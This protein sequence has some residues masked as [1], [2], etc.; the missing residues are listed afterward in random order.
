MAIKQHVSSS[1]LDRY[2]HY[3]KKNRP[4]YYNAHLDKS[5][6]L[7]ER[8]LHALSWYVTR[9]GMCFSL[10]LVVGI[11]SEIWIGLVLFGATYGISSFMF[12]QI[13][14]KCLEPAPNRGLSKEDKIVELAR[15]QRHERAGVGYGALAL[16]FA[17]LIYLNATSQ[18]FGGINLYASYATIILSVIYGFYQLI[19]YFARH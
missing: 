2:V 12:Y 6:Y 9:F 18:N 8:Q 7:T 17:A 15:Q 1:P 3:D 14:M 10:A 19:H 11:L 5:F 13:F 16:V 4:I